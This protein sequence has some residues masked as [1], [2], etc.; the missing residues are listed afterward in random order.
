MSHFDGVEF[1]LRLTRDNRLV[2]FHD[3]HLSPAQREV[4]DGS[5]WTEDHTAAELG[6]LGIATFETLLEDADFVEGWRTH[7]KVACVEL[8]MPNPKS[9]A[10]GYVSPKKREVHARRMAKQVDEILAEVDL[11]HASVVLISFKRRFRKA[12]AK[13]GVRW[14]VAQ[15]QPAIPE[16]GTR[17][18]KRILTLPSFMW[19]SM[20]F[21][22]KHQQL[23]GAPMLPC[24]LEYLDGFPRHL[25]LG[26]TVGL[27]GYTSR[28]LTRI[29]NGFQVF[30]WPCP[31]RV[32]QGVRDL[33]LTGMTD[34]TSPD[35]V[36]L[37]DGGARWTR[38]ASQPLDVEREILLRNAAPS[39]HA[40]LIEEANR[41]VTPWRELTDIERR[42]FLSSWRK[43]WQWDREIDELA[44]DAAADRMPWEVSRL[45]G[46]RGSGEDFHLRK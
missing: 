33:G 41:E 7:G 34:H 18:I 1:D 11:P 38:W 36:T 5:K 9:K 28:R 40:A 43:R 26:R 42:G 13:A 27:S 45:I 20:A 21:H 29:R 39:D 4:L 15:L 14:P 16:I 19:L 25:T 2:I 32:E 24:A 8:K 46:H 23:V 44:T 30:V 31:P 37:P 17:T 22:L 3:N 12:C 6:E 10:A 35:L